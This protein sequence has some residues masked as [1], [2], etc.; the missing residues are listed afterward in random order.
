MLP[1]RMNNQL[2]HTRNSLPQKVRSEAAALLQDRLWDTIDLTLQAKQA[3]WNVKG[4]NFF[5]L[6]EL[7]D[8]VY[9]HAAAWMDILAERIVQLGGI[10]CGTLKQTAEKT[11]LP[12]FP[13][14]ISSGAKNVATLAH[15]LAF[16][17][18]LMAKAIE[19]TGSLGDAVTCDIFTEI[20]R[21]AQSD[22][23]FLEAQEQA[24]H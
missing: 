3:H 5:A 24:E 16:Y 8:K 18:E 6:H 23:W 17:S 10:A 9:T 4:A 1:A 20:S 15:A 14:E 21:G 19:L 12:A 11:S 13:E 7:F 22:L 2:I